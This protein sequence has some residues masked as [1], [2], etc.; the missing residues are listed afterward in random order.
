M[1]DI[2]TV[3]SQLLSPQERATGIVLGEKGVATAGV[4]T[5]QVAPRQA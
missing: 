1:G 5:F 3:S 2:V 4:S